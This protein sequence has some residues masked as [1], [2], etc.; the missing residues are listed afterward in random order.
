MLK[1][2]YYGTVQLQITVFLVLQSN[3][4]KKKKQVIAKNIEGACPPHP[5]LNPLLSSTDS[6]QITKSTLYN[7]SNREPSP[8]SFVDTSVTI[9]KNEF[10]CVDLFRALP[11]IFQLM[12][13]HVIAAKITLQ[14]QTK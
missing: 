7:N 13:E 9:K 1:M 5:P 8:T 2:H 3:C 12:P 6:S 11:R 4:K 14:K 10:L